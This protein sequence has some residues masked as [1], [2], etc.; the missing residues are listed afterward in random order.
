MDVALGLAESA[1]ILLGIGIISGKFG[2][3][4]GLSQLGTGIQTL[5][6]A[7]LTGTGT[8][9]SVF[10]GGLRDV[11]QTFG[12]LG[13]GLGDLFANIPTLPTIPGGGLPGPG[14]P[15]PVVAPPSVSRPPIWNL[16]FPVS[17]ETKSGGG[18]SDLLAGGSGSTPGGITPG[19]GVVY[20][21]ARPR[22]PTNTTARMQGSG[23]SV[24]TG[25]LR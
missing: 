15:P 14:N 19:K 7:P 21:V 23:G 17:L 3:G 25:M 4:T 22:T 16:T 9:L 6:A 10:A 1:A 12:D 5:V 24:D 18:G 8:G 13:R 11:F 20:M 2:A